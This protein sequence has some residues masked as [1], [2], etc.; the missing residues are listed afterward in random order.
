MTERSVNVLPLPPDPFA[1][2]QN[3]GD[4]VVK[5]GPSLS[6]D[7]SR[8]RSPTAI[9]D[10]APMSGHAVL[11]HILPGQSKS[12]RQSSAQAPSSGMTPPSVSSRAEPHHLEST[13]LKVRQA[14]GQ[15]GEDEQPGAGISRVRPPV[16]GKHVAPINTQPPRREL[17]HPL[18][19]SPGQSYLSG[20]PVDG[21]RSGDSR[22]L[23]GGNQSGSGKQPGGEDTCCHCVLESRDCDCGCCHRG[24][25][26]VWCCGFDCGKFWL[27][28]SPC[29]K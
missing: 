4:L 17:G 20:Q 6:M 16:A 27:C 14:G 3:Q 5:R 21:G 7:I 11:N 19:S 28:I 15:A 22:P 18:A 29:S 10:G 24:Y 9:D 12:L 23:G 25:V 2:G 1:E 26:R 8:E 13:R